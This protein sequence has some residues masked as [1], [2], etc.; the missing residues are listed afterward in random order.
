LDGGDGLR[1]G[2]FRPGLRALVL[3]ALAL[4]LIA[5]YRPALEDP[6]TAFQ[7]SLG[8]SMALT[9]RADVSEMGDVKI[10][11]NC[12]GTCSILELVPQ[13]GL[14]LGRNVFSVKEFNA[15][16]LRHEL[17]HVRQSEEKGFLWVPMYLWEHLR[18]APECG[19]EYRCYHD[20]NKFEAEARLAETD[21]DYFLTRVEC[22]RCLAG[23]PA[24]ALCGVCDWSDLR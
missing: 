6:R 23:G 20:H 24:G 15:A 21:R 11:E 7:E 2:G 4:P 3:L 9:S 12:V 5:V 10:Y 18:H 13:S 8:I 17:T 1:G 19:L 16:T 22:W 14:A